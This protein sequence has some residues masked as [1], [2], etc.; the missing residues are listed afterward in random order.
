MVEI[1]RGLQSIYHE[2]VGAIIWAQTQN[3]EKKG[4]VRKKEQGRRNVQRPST[5]E[6]MVARKNL[7]AWKRSAKRKWEDGTQGYLER[8]RDS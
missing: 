8:T 1:V 6:L 5:I 7:K 2:V 4:W 3:K